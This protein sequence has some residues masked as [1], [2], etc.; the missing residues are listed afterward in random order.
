M[1]AL[2]Y[3]G[4][5]AVYPAAIH[6]VMNGDQPV[7]ITWEVPLEELA[8]R[9]EFLNARYEHIFVFSSPG[10]TAF[11]MTAPAF[12]RAS[13]VEFW[14]IGGGQSGGRASNTSHG[15]GGAAG[16]R[17]SIFLPLW[18]VSGW[19]GASD[20]RNFEVVVGAGGVQQ[21]SVNSRGNPGEASYVRELNLGGPIVYASGG[22]QLSTALSYSGSAGT[23]LYAVDPTQS[24]GDAFDASLIDPSSGVRDLSMATNHGTTW[25]LAQHGL[26]GGGKAGTIGPDVGGKAGFGAGSGGGGGILT[27]GG[28]GGGTALYASGGHGGYP[29]RPSAAAQ[30]GIAGTTNCYGG[31]GA[32][33]IVFARVTFR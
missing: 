18:D 30:D 28:I 4:N 2:T 32:S 23:C 10:T 11:D 33:G 9:T 21:T 14:V 15:K 26:S 1:S 5:P 19:F 22:G 16:A 24:P 31:A 12:S 17:N 8:D 27:T 13:S 6:K 25:G 3:P 29:H 7:G 20:Y